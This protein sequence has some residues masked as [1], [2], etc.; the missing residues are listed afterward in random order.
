MIAKEVLRQCDALDGIADGLVSNYTACDRRFD[1]VKTPNPLAAVRCEGGADTGESCLSAAQ[2][3]AA[4]AVHG[5]MSYPFPLAN[6]WTSL[7]V[8]ASGLKKR[9]Q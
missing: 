6:G 9:S 4:N 2:I 7:P 8:H 5:S 3:R 1:P